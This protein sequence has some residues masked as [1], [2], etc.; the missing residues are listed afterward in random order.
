[1]ELEKEILIYKNVSLFQNK[2]KM[3]ATTEHNNKY[4]GWIVNSLINFT[5]SPRVGLNT[6]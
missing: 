1:M 5:V 6:L 4:H 2:N 3:V